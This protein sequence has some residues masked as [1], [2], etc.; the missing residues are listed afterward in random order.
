MVKTEA[1]RLRAV[2]FDIPDVEYSHYND[3]CTFDYFLEKKKL[4]DPAL[5]ALQ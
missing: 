3:K 2:S 1:K 5:K 4:N